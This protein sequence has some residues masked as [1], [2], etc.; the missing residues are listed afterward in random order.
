MKDQTHTRLA[1]TLYEKIGRL[2]VEHDGLAQDFAD[3]RRIRVQKARDLLDV[4]RERDDAQRVLSEAQDEL[5]QLRDKVAEQVRC[6]DEAPISGDWQSKYEE[7]QDLAAA[8]HRTA[9]E[10]RQELDAAREKHDL[11]HKN[12]RQACHNLNRQGVKLVALKNEHHAWLSECQQENDRLRQE[13]R[14]MTARAEAG[15]GAHGVAARERAAAQVDTRRLQLEVD[16]LHG[17]IRSYAD[18]NEALSN[19]LDAYHYEIQQLRRDLAVASQQ[20]DC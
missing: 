17:T 19:Q 8:W 9:N 4:R 16:E 10:F 7:Q 6:T 18:R 15:N 11:L 2:V 1:D 5:D 13:L 20:Q 3:E 12:W 14:Q